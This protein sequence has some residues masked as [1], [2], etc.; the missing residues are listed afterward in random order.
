MNDTI[1]IPPKI[2]VGYQNRNDTYTK[3][4][5]YII[6]FDEKG[7][8]RK[9][10][11]WNSW[12][13]KNIP[14]DVYEN[15][16]TEGFVLNKKVGDYCCDWNHRQAYIRVYDPRDFEFEITIENLLYILENTSSIKGKGL[17]GKFVYGWKG[18]DLVLMPVNSPDYKEISEYTNLLLEN[19]TIKAKDLIIGATYRTKQ[20]EEW[21]YMG[22]YDEYAYKGINRGK[23]FWFARLNKCWNS[24]KY[25]YFF[26]QL[27]TIPKNKLIQVINDKCC[28]NYSDI[29]DK[30]ECVSEYSP[31]DDS[32]DKFEYYTLEEFK[33]KKYR[34]QKY[35]INNSKKIRI[36]VV[37]LDEGNFK[38]V[39][40]HIVRKESY[41][42][43]SYY[44]S[45]EKQTENIYNDLEEIYNK[46][47]PQYINKYLQNGK[48]YKREEA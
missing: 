6:Y 3:K 37:T 2:N 33:N 19:K 46:Y 38:V 45:W 14:N 11:S 34:W 40:E 27:K 1:F 41:W 35:Y 13:D 17:E 10:T 18:K 15:V 47:K 32:K 26:E 7:K 30:M 21:I 28:D 36:E 22:K 20:N 31:I 12:R 8:L 42:N 25:K 39:Q 16:P 29:F 23:Q 44:N 4:L 24:D 43:N 5:A 9:E 48:L